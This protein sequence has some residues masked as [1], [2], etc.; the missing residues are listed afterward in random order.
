MHYHIYCNLKSISNSYKKAIM[1]FEKR[2]SAYCDTSLHISTTLSFPKKLNENNQHFFL[3]NNGPST[4][5][6]EEFSEQLNT[7]QHSG[8]S[9]VHIIIGFSEK[10]FYASV[11][12]S[13]FPVTFSL[14][15]SNLCVE[16]LALLF[17]EQLYRAYTILQG[18][19]YHK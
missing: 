9:I 12:E 16:T 18:K 11:S 13:V 6:S 8:K 17:Y 19:T 14:T 2:L 10:E 5:S 3:M 7:L 4:Y 1:E 15:R